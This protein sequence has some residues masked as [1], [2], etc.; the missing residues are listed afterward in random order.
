MRVLQ[1]NDPHS[2][3]SLSCRQATVAVDLTAVCHLSLRDLETCLWDRC[4]SS[5][6]SFE[7]VVR[8]SSQGRGV[9]VVPARQSSFLEKHMLEMGFVTPAAA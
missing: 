3:L 2:N 9:W 8:T 5:L 1:K 7:G 4:L 6:V